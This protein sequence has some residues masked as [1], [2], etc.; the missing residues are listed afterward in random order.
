[1]ELPQ[2]TV[3]VAN[4]LVAIDSSGVRFKAFR[5]GVGPYGEPQLLRLVAE[6]LNGLNAYRG[7]VATKRTPDLL[8]KGQWALE[9]K[10]ARPF[11]DNGKPAENWSVNLLH[12][13]EGNV[14]AVGDCFKL[15]A[16][17]GPERR[18]V[19]V[20]GYEHTPPLIDLAPLLSAFE[21]VA[22][23]VAHIDLGPRFQETR[24]KLVHPVHQQ[25]TVTA[26]EVIGRSA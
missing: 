24:Y 7:T 9:F 20:I 23:R 11:G 3:D 18:A 1:M 2:I 13:Y 8:L 12:P 19:V 4:V 22:S 17:C 6:G 26:W 14:S 16:L 5:A 25:L 15:L 10:I 21:V